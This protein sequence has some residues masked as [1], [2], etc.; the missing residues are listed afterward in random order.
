MVPFCCF[1]VSTAVIISTFPGVLCI[2]P[3]KAVLQHSELILVYMH[4][5][6]AEYLYKDTWQQSSLDLQGEPIMGGCLACSFL[7]LVVQESRGAGG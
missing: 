7:P 4:L 3:P 5:P 2:F 6:E 1:V